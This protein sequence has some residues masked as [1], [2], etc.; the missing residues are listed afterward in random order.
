MRRNGQRQSRDQ[1]SRHRTPEL[2]YYFIVTDTKETEQNYI[3]KLR[4]SVPENL[5]GKL[6]IKVN[7]TR[8]QIQSLNEFKFLN[9]NL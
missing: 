8:I 3:Y 4:D 1:L 2:G 9:F 6:V 5:I 7:K